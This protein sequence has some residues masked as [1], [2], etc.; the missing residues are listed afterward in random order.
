MAQVNPSPPSHDDPRPS[1]FQPS[2]TDAAR[3][4]QKATKQLAQRNAR[5][6]N[7]THLITAAIH[8]IFIGRRMLLRWRRLE[9]RSVALYV[10]L[11]GPGLFLEFWL[12]RIGR[13]SYVAGT[14]DVRRPGEDLEAK[15][16]TEYM[17]DVIYWTWTCTLVAAAFGDRAWWLWVSG[18]LSIHTYI[19]LHTSHT[20]IHT[21]ACIYIYVC[22]L[23]VDTRGCID[24]FSCVRVQCSSNI[25]SL[26]VSFFG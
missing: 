19:Q 5:T 8:A 22:V 20:Y 15:G 7:R 21:Y 17:W 11:G 9:P 24:D 10:L 16:L 3:P 2:P 6:L 1:S 13:P 26:I 18:L 12:E 23:S 14:R 25:R 4:S